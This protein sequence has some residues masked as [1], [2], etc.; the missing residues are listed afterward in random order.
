MHGYGAAD[1]RLTACAREGL[2]GG[3]PGRRNRRPQPNSGTDF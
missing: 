2:N 3:R 1:A